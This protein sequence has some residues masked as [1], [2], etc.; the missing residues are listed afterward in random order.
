MPF[1]TFAAGP[2]GA[3][4][5]GR[6]HGEVE[7]VRRWQRHL[8]PTPVRGGAWSPD[9]SFGK[10]DGI[11]RGG[12]C[13]CLMTFRE[14]TDT[15]SDTFTVPT[16]G[17][18]ADHAHELMLISLVGSS[19]A[20]NGP[21]KLTF[22]EAVLSPSHNSLDRITAGK[23]PIVFRCF[24]YVSEDGKVVWFEEGKRGE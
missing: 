4:Y 17:R 16:G 18:L 21:A 6:C 9:E 19:T 7:G 15:E 8:K 5:R 1:A 2:Y 12:Q 14:W 23:V 20:R 3:T 13:F 11:Y 22:G 24:P 10:V